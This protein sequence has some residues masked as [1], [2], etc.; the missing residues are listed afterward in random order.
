MP[1]RSRGHFCYGVEKEKHFVNVHLHCTVTNMERIS[2]ISSLPP[3][4]KVSADTHASDMKFFQSSDIFPTR[5]GCFLPAN[6]TNKKIFEL[7]KVLI[8]YLFAVFKVSRP[9]TFETRPETFETE[10]RK[11]GSRDWDQVTRPGLQSRKS[12]HP[13]PTPG[14]FDSP[15]PTFSCIS[16]LKW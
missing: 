7:Y 1:L 5:F 12:R 10:T 8:N 6:T 9:K 11:H 16:Y 3:S 4:G 15:T 13:T 14:N 2:K